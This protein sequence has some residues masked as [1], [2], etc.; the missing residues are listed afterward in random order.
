MSYHNASTRSDW[1]NVYWYWPVK[2]RSGT[3]YER[4]NLMLTDDTDA[5]HDWAEAHWWPA[6]RARYP[7]PEADPRDGKVDVVLLALPYDAG[8]VE[9]E[10]LFDDPLLVDDDDDIIDAE[11][12]DEQ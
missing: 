1:T 9:I 11:I 8:A 10:E 2:G 4:I 6:L 7:D 5:H 3:R 12:V